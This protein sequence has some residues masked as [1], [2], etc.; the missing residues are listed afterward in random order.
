[1]HGLDKAGDIFFDR[2]S[3]KMV[4]VIEPCSLEDCILEGFRK[5]LASAGQSLGFSFPPHL[6]S[7]LSGRL[8]FTRIS[9]KAVC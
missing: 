2:F 9:R 5:C 7:Q 3:L 8:L 6:R 1:M 4:P